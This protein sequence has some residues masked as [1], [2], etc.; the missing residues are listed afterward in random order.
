MPFQYDSNSN[1]TRG[2]ASGPGGTYPAGPYVTQAGPG[3][4]VAPGGP[5]SPEN[6][7]MENRD[8]HMLGRQPKDGVFTF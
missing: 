8:L 1:A 2:I 5:R 7:R 3:K 4:T 6:P